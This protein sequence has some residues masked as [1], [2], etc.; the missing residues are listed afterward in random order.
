[1]PIKK[2]FFIL[3]TACLA[4]AMDEVKCSFLFVCLYGLF[5]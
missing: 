1:M 5:D 3:N 4:V 2:I